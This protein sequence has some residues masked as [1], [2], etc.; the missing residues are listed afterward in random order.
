MAKKSLEKML[1]SIEEEEAGN[2]R[3]MTVR[4]LKANADSKRSYAEKF[5]DWITSA[6]G[7]ISFLVVNVFVFAGWI[8]ANVGAIPGITPFD[9]YP[10]GFLT[11]CVSLEAIVLAIIVLISQNRDA[12][13][14]DIREEIDLNI[15]R[16]AETEITQIIKMLS[17]VLEKQGI[18]TKDDKVLQRMLRPLSSGDIQRKIELQTQKHHNKNIPIP[19]LPIPSVF[20][21]NIKK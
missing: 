10:F 4:S 6:S 20:H 7:S 18:D 11:M 1:T 8:L 16:I 2:S 19:D 3:G 9:P 14:G 12:R 17:L 13:I 21:E 5:A 15:N